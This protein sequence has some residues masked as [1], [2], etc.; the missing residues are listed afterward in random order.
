MDV[1]DIVSPAKTAEAK[2]QVASEVMRRFMMFKD[3][4]LHYLFKE[5]RF[6]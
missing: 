4:A 2:R 1:D 6:S 3:N 5:Y